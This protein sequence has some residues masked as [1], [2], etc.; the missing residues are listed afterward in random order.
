MFT[1]FWTKNLKGRHYL[2]DLGADGG[3]NIRMDLRKVGW[4][5]V[6]WMH[7]AQGRVQRRALLNT[8]MNFRVS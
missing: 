7:L 2:E 6:D 4:K 1:K 8:R 5:G 3:V